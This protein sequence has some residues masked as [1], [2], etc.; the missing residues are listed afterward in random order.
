MIPNGDISI[1]IDGVNPVRTSL[2]EAIPVLSGRLNN[3]A[4]R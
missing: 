1:M 2:P 4:L 3:T